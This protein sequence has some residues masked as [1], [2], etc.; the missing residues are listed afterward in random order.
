MTSC[1]TARERLAAA[2]GAFRAS[3][4]VNAPSANAATAQELHSRWVCGLCPREGETLHHGRVR[5]TDLG[6]WNRGEGADFL[7]AEI[8][9]NGVRLS[10]DIAVDVNAADWERHAEDPRYDRVVLH[11]VLHRPPA[12]WFTRNA[13]HAEVPLFCLCPPGEAR[14]SAPAGI[15]C[16]LAAW[17]TE[18]A[19]SLLDAAAAYRAEEKRHRFLRKAETLGRSQAL[20][21]AW[22]E[23]LGYSANKLSMQCL[24]HRAP[25]KALAGEAAEALLFGTAGFLVPVLPERCSPEARAYHR[26]LWDAWWPRQEQY[27][28]SGCRALTWQ[29][30]PVRPMNHPQRRV[31]ALAAGAQQWGALEPLMGVATAARL[32]AA[33]TALSHPYWDTHCTLPSAAMPRRCA[34]VGRQRAD[35]F[36]LNH[37]Y[38]HD[39]GDA[40]W[41]S[42]RALKTK[43]IPQQAQHTAAALF[44]GSDL[45]GR[46][47][48]QRA[49]VQQ[50]LLQLAADFADSNALYPAALADWQKP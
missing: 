43:E 18:R 19:K 28:L 6:I 12:G 50:G 5:I 11:A 41:Q 44:G 15:P 4:R 27:R 39:A 36:L 34:L 42:Y 35:D 9:L 26:R 23:T 3:L 33:L 38:A 40:S 25:L 49:A 32:R 24:A 48:L 1:E 22:A 46:E 45:L 20:F 14:A 13:A 2:Y 47:L 8:E 16:P 21:E 29:L 17:D 10:G 31:A 37:I 30:S 7:R